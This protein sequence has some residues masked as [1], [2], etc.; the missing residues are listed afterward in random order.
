MGWMTVD[1]APNNGTAIHGVGKTVNADYERD[2]AWDPTQHY[3]R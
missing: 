3:V 2:E 1:N